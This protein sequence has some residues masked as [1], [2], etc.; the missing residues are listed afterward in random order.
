MNEE[1]IAERG[2]GWVISKKEVEELSPSELELLRQRR[3]EL[4]SRYRVNRNE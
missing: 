2:Y 1:E 3:R 4:G